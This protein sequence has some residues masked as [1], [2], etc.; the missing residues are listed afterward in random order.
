MHPSTG[1]YNAQD[2]AGPERSRITLRMAARFAGREAGR[3]TVIGQTAPRRSFDRRLMGKQA[4][5]V[6]MLPRLLRLRDAP[7]YLG[8]DRNRFNADV[9]PF[10]TEISIGSQGI[11]FDRLDLDAWADQYK[12]RNGRPGQPIGD[13]LWDAK[14]RRASICGKGSGISTSRF[15]DDEFAKALAKATSRKRR[16]I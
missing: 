13:Q 10:V 14:H 11:A 15:V 6:H 8:M 2:G 5:A 7:R 1:R 16:R 3:P 12:S 9:R 4:M